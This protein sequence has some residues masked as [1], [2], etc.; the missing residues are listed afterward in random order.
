MIKKGSLFSGLG[1]TTALVPN[2]LWHGIEYAT[3]NLMVA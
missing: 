2:V 1:M 3:Q